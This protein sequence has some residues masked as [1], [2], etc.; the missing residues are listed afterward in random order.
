MFASLAFAALDDDA[1]AGSKQPRT[2]RMIKC[3]IFMMN[4]RQVK[5]AL[6]LR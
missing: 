6:A 2:R 5:R 1:L 3:A 4:L